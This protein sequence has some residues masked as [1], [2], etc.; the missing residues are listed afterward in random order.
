[1]TFLAPFPRP[2][3]GSQLSLATLDEANNTDATTLSL[4][5]ASIFPANVNLIAVATDGDPL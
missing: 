3:N 2:S 4:R 5:M 1:M